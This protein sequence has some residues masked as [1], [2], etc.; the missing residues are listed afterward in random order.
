MTIFRKMISGEGCREDGQRWSWRNKGQMRQDLVDSV[1]DLEF[2]SKKKDSQG[3]E[4]EG[5][6]KGE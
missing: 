6:A 3:L 1:S 4:G 2:Y 5:Q